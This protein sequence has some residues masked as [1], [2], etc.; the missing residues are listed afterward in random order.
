TSMPV[1]AIGGSGP[2]FVGAVG[3]TSVEAR[4]V[5]IAVP[6]YAA[7]DLLRQRAPELSDRRRSVPYASTATTAM[8][9]PRDAVAPSP[10][11]SGVLVRRVERTGIMAASWLSSK[12]PHRAPEGRV[13]MRAFVGGARDPQAL[14]LSDDELVTR[15]MTALRPL[16]RITGDP[17]FTRIYRWER[18]SAQHEV[19]HLER[20]AEL[21][22]A[23]A[24]HS[25]L[26]LTGSGFRGVGVPDCI[27][28]G[29][30]TGARVADW[31]QSQDAI[32]E[33]TENRRSS[34]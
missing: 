13:L 9:V 28:D 23:L 25:G 14:E 24:R 4:A 30:R 19:G 33:T 29:R 3:G 34:R 2:F 10:T 16:L 20:T 31:L 21:Y 32:R 27:L 5:V 12:W 26:F 15:S 7:A 18:A 6:A 11:R 17:L 22:R 8:A 1:N